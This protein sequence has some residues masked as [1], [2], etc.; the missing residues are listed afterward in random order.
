MR[1]L[2]GRRMLTFLNYGERTEF[3]R[4]WAVKDELTRYHG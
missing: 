1:R 4:N 2:D 3:V